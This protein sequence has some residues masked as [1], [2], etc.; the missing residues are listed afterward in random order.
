MVGNISF[1]MHKTWAPN[2]NGY[3]LGIKL[4]RA[5]AC[6]TAGVCTGPCGRR[7][8]ITFP[9]E[10]VLSIQYRVNYKTKLFT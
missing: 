2:M 6:I 8:G 7:M 9:L 4:I 3:L 5:H 1:F 10:N